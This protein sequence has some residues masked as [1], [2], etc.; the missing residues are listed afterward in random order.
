M[1]QRIAISWLL[2]LSGYVIAHFP[3]GLLAERI[4]GKPVILMSLFTSALLTILTPAAVVYGGVSAL[5]IVRVLLGVVQAGMYPAVATLLAVWIPQRER[6]R[7]GSIVY[8]SGPVSLSLLALAQVTSDS[9]T[10]FGF[11]L[12]VRSSAQCSGI[13][14]PAT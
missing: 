5:F 4:G 11:V 12:D 9:Q 3:G 1:M 8:C 7:V 13:P 6:A 2:F 10:E 14:P